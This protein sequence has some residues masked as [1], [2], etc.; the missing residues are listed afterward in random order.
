V[1]KDAE[2]IEAE[3]RSVISMF[4]RRKPSADLSQT[5]TP[6]KLSDNKVKQ[7]KS[8]KML[9]KGTIEKALEMAVQEKPKE[10][11]EK[12]PREKPQPEV[13]SA[14][15]EPPKSE[16]EKADKSSSK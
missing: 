8:P 15:K 14:E 11:P 2:A 4:E 10:K 12:P 9:H 16:K 13:K 7:I 6:S 3:K 1:P 5:S